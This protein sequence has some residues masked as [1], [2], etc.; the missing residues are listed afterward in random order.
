[1]DEKPMTKSRMQQ[2]KSL[3]EEIAMLGGRISAAISTGGIERD[4][5][6]GS[7]PEHPYT[8]RNIIIEGYGSGGPEVQRLERRRRTLELE[9]VAVEAYIE[10]V[11]DSKMRQILTWR[12]LHGETV[13]ETARLV[14]YSETHVKRLTKE[15]FNGITH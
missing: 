11:A 9:C 7:L 12:Y 14:G 3:R 5:V 1:M 13:E 2:Y 15:F 6:R 8:V 4:M 10:A